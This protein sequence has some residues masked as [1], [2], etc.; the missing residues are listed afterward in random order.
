LILPSRTRS[1]AIAAGADWFGR[2]LLAPQCHVGF[3]T[4]IDGRI[5]RIVDSLAVAQYRTLGHPSRGTHCERG[6]SLPSGSGW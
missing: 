2:L 5:D 6:P 1:S 3:V 4:A